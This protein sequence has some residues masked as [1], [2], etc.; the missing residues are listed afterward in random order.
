[1]I[2]SCQLT[3]RYLRTEANCSVVKLVDDNLMVL[4]IKS[5]RIDLREVRV[6]L[7]SLTRGVGFILEGAKRDGTSR[8]ICEMQYASGGS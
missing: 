7:T 8:S 1:M 4:D 3:S 2:V 5:G 6:N